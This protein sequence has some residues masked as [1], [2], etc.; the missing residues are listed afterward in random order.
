VDP[1]FGKDHAAV[2][3]LASPVGFPDGT[4]LIFDFEYNNNIHHSIGR[5]RLS[6]TSRPGP[7]GIDGE[8]RP[9]L[10]VELCEKL[11]EG[12]R[13]EGAIAVYA[14]L[15]E[16][17][18]RL[19]KA[20]DVHLAAKPTPKITKVLVTTEGLKPLKHHADERG[21][22]HFYKETYVLARGDVNKKQEVATQGFIQV[23]E[24][25]ADETRWVAPSPPGSRTPGR[26]AALARWLTDVDAGAGPLLARVIVNRLW[27]QHFGRGIVATTNDF[28]VQGDPPSHPEL[29]DALAAELIRGGW[30]LKSIHKLILTSAAYRRSTEVVPAS[31]AKDPDNRLYWRRDPRRLE[32]EAIRD[33]LLDAG[34]LLD[35]TMYGPG[36]LDEGMTRRSIYF[37]IKR[38][39]L[40]PMMMVF[41]A[42]EPLASQGSRPTTTIAPQALLFM[43]SPLVRRCAAG[44]AKE[45][46]VASI[47]RRALGRPPTERELKKASEF[48][49]TQEK[50]YRDAGKADPTSA[51]R[52]DFCQAVLCLNEFVYVD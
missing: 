4:E 18:K 23:L 37:F 51:A 32:A 1:Q 30:R 50:S 8:S 12:K 29:L 48:L 15:D 43:N 46:D 9:Q 5:P 33:S 47:Y 11:R 25:G 21:F 7:V 6:V 38:S 2:F 28:G 39:R 44:L 22:P 20:V 49:S 41:D 14:L 10:V 19:Q 24:R 16:E 27:A 36:T 13:P 45:G 34:G 3:E 26:R 52:V 40:I 31:A 35:R 42:P 17:A